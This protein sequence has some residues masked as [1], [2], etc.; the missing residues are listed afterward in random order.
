MLRGLRLRFKKCIS[1]AIIFFIVDD[2]KHK[3]I[4]PIAS[5]HRKRSPYHSNLLVNKKAG[6]KRTLNQTDE[7]NS[8]RATGHE[9]IMAKASLLVAI[10]SP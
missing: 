8:L 5:S 10:R 1:E 7:V 3:G 2:Q 6:R 9:S 4:P